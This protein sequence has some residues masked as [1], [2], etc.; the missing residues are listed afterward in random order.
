MQ[1]EACAMCPDDLFQ[2]LAPNPAI[3]VLCSMNSLSGLSRAQSGLDCRED[4]VTLCPQARGNASPPET[5]PGCPGRPGTWLEPTSTLLQ[6][7]F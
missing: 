5:Q 1:I 2:N 7:Q 3:K 4:T 6:E